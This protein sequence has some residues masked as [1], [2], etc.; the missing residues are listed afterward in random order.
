MFLGK[1]KIKDRPMFRNSTEFDFG[2]KG[3]TVIHG[4]NL[5]TGSGNNTNAAG[6]SLLFSTVQ[7]LCYRE[8]LVGSRRDRVTEGLVSLEIGKTRDDLSRV[9]SKNKKLA[10][11]NSSGDMRYRE[12][13]E[14][15]AFI[16][17]VIPQSLVAYATLCHIDD[18]VPHPL[19]RGETAARREF[20]TKFFELNATD[21]RR[22]LIADRVSSAKAESRLLESYRERLAQLANVSSA[23]IQNLSGTVA[24]LKLAKLK[25]QSSVDAFSE[26]AVLREFLRDYADQLLKA[27]NL[28]GVRSE[29]SELESSLEALDANLEYSSDLAAW[30]KQRSRRADY[31]EANGLQDDSSWLSD[32]KRDAR[33]K[34]SA[35]AA[36]AA[37]VAAL[38]AKIGT[39]R[40]DLSE[41][42]EALASAESDSAEAQCESCG[43][44][45]TGDLRKKHDAHVAQQVTRLA[46]KV[47][48]LK[49]NGKSAKADLADAKDAALSDRDLSKLRT[50]LEALDNVPSVGAKPSKP[51]GYSPETAELDREAITKKLKVLR[52]TLD[53]YHWASGKTFNLAKA[54]SPA[55]IKSK[56]NESDPTDAYIQIVDK[57]AS[58]T[59]D[60][61]LG[62]KELVEK[63]T[64][65]EKLK[66][67]EEE[68]GNA[69]ALEILDK[70][71][72]PRG[73][74][75][76]LINSV[77][78]QLERILNQYAKLI[79]D[80]PHTFSLDLDKQFHITVTRSAKGKEETSDVRR[81]SGAESSMFSLLLWLGL[82]SFVPKK[83][84]PNF[85]IL[86]ELDSR[87]SEPTT[88]KFLSF[89]PRLLTV[90]DHVIVITP[91]SEVRYEHTIP[92]VRYLTVVKTGMSSELHEGSVHTVS[93]N[94]KSTTTKLRVKKD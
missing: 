91:R 93:R 45:L 33:S 71:Y 76:V 5:N 13:A 51:P 74:R 24:K 1:L 17:S 54:L 20:F 12:P 29:I 81:L 86:D 82:M 11:L 43:A 3:L 70:A 14:I 57:L 61:E 75:R 37:N 26:D 21:N 41:A 9:V 90:V 22:K 58:A 78:S 62:K 49:A 44:D 31:L 85:L 66:L 39:I 69:E 46:S 48:K 47:S 6:K 4:L 92:E 55:Q 52:A 84:R 68:L 18:R 59:L 28:K 10:I 7:D 65:L 94:V 2:Y 25:M 88:E 40:E 36:A 80:E 77:C 53:E 87:M 63:E 30:R 89:L 38:E 64:L 60:Y 16:K 79:Y 23:G 83:Q 8:V 19:I 32:N 67:A 27:P 50:K 42:K 34:I 15:D 73:F 72:S 56:L 35:S